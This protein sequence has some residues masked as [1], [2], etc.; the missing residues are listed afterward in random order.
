MKAV[1]ESH[2]LHELDTNNY[3]S[4]INQDLGLLQRTMKF[5]P[6]SCMINPIVEPVA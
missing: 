2:M 3:N 6:S 1:K 4:D 5:K